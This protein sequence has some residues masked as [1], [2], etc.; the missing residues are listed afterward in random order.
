MIARMAG[1]MAA[2]RLLIGSGQR[3][4]GLTLVRSLYEHVVT[5]CWFMIDPERRLKRLFDH[6]LASQRTLHKDAAPFGLTL[7]SEDELEQS[8]GKSRLP[9]LPQLAT[10][11]DHYWGPRIRGF[12]AQ[13]ESG[14]KDILTLSGMYVGL[15]RIASRSA[16]PTIE[17]LDPC[18]ES[19]AG[20][21]FVRTESDEKP[22]PF[23]FALPLFAMALLVCHQVLRWPRRRCRALFERLA[24][25]GRS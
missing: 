18:V 12:R 22:L 5:L 14:P 4:D 17:G 15:Y 13:P 8:R 9:K 23:G 11:V 21:V 3:S 7:L 24:V 16:H 1:T 10:E 20:R 6:S 2:L 19:S 25:L